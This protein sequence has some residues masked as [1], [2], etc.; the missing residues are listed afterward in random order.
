MLSLANAKPDFIKWYFCAKI[1]DLIF[2]INEVN[3]PVSQ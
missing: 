1:A 3:N 2:V